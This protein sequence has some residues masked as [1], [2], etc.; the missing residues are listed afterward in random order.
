MPE[1]D[2][3]KGGLV[4]CQFLYNCV[5]HLAAQGAETPLSALCME[6]VVGRGVPACALP[7]ALRSLHAGVAASCLRVV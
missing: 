1:Y 6:A 2:S 4:D 3:V 7:A 5:V